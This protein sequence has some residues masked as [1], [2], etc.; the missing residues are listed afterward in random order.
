MLTGKALR[1]SLERIPP[2][3]VTGVYWR[4]VTA[5]SLLGLAMGHKGQ[6]RA[7]RSGVWVERGQA[8][9]DRSNA[10]HLCRDPEGDVVSELVDPDC[11]FLEFDHSDAS[12]EVCE[13]S[14]CLGATG[15][16]LTLL[17]LGDD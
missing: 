13:E 9:S 14:Y 17:I 4:V 11:W 5:S 15:Y 7:D 8:L 10:W 1:D 3:R 2:I 16:V 6:P 12:L